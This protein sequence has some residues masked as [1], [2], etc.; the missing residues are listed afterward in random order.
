MM[1]ELSIWLV[2]TWKVLLGYISLVIGVLQLKLIILGVSSLF[3]FSF[4][5]VELNSSGSVFLVQTKAGSS[6]FSILS[7]IAGWVRW[8]LEV[9]KQKIFPNPFAVGT[10]VQVLELAGLFSPGR[11]KLYSLKP[12][13]RS[14]SWEGACWWVGAEAGPSAF[15]CQQERTPYQPYGSI[16]GVPATPEAPEGVCYGTL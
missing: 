13:M 10:G 6:L 11:G 14:H 9:V 2:S 15:V 8:D 4:L 12:A 7:L 16:W 1:K 3:S 5:S